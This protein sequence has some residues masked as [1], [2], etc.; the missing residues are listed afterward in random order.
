MWSQIRSALALTVLLLLCDRALAADP[1]VELHQ[2]FDDE[3]DRTMR[4]SPTWASSLGDLRFNDRWPDASLEAI[5][6]SQAARKAALERLRRID[7]DR[8]NKVDRHNYRLFEREYESDVAGHRFR[9]YVLPINQRGGIQD[10]NS[11]ADSLRFETVKDFDDWITRLKSFPVYA[12][13]ITALMREGMRTGMMHPRIVMSRIPGQLKRQIVSD[14]T[15]SLYYKPFRSIPNDI[16]TAERERIRAEA[17]R[18]VS[19]HIVP[20]YRKFAAFFRD[21]YLAACLN[22]VGVWQLPGGRELYQHRARVFTTTELTPR[23][24]HDIGLR[25]VA[26]IRAEMQEVVEQV[27]F[28]GSF[29]EFLESLRTDPKHFY[30]NPNDLIA[31][32][33]ECCRRID[34][35]LPKLFQR[36]PKIPYNIEQIP[37]NMAPDTTTA[38]YRPPSADGRRPGTYF[39]NLYK[40][41]VRPKYEVEALSLH[42]SVPGHHLQIALAMELDELPEFRRYG[43]YTAFVEGWALYSE[44][45][46]EE[47]GLYQ[48][49]YSKFGQLTYEMWRAVRLVVDTGMHAFEWPR[50]RAIA[51]FRSNTAK[52]QTDIEN[53][54]DRYISWPGQALAYKIGELKIRELRS[55]AEQQLQ[56]GFDVREFH[57]VV[58]RNGAV[59]L[60]ILEAEVTMW[61]K[62][63]Q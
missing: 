44:K 18:A 28:K 23:E 42:E 3:W 61:L 14:P 19:D 5:E 47:L 31:A 36:L 25:E 27:K 43:G 9:L 50:E 16:P 52:T 1:A 41:E 12:D 56:D 4:E 39:V 60:D 63:K 57:D 34:P 51:F 45:L 58:L 54:V 2:L 17:T 20:A 10:E 13:Q 55:R 46:G 37:A 6:R 24:I 53:E 35:E 40:P 48:D 7:F 38:Y 21:E 15:A 26:R 8:L 49:P 33:R 62:E 32:Y 11:T 59:T 29:D 30:T 22:K